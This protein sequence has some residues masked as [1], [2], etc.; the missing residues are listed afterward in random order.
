MSK[1]LKIEITES[2]SE[3]RKEMRKSISMIAVRIN[4]L[5]QLKKH[6]GMLSRRKL[7]SKLGVCAQSI[8][9]WRKV[10]L[11]GGLPALIKHNRKGREFKVLND[12]HREFIDQLVGNPENGLQGYTELQKVMFQKFDKNFVYSTLRMY[13]YFV[14]KG[15]KYA[16]QVL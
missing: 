13:S 1:A 12:N 16:V 9:T 14:P 11:E 3:L 2:V 5:L 4:M 6:N 15:H 10:Y 8:Q 7:A